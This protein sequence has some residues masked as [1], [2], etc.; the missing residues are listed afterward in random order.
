MAA[1]AH[2]AREN[3]KKGGRPKGKL[4]KSTMDAIAVKSLYVEKA[5]EYAL[6]ILQALV[7]KAL[8]GDVAAIREFNDRAYGK[9]LQK[10]ESEVNLTAV[11][12]SDEE[13]E[14]INKTLDA[15]NS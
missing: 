15:I 8:E 9:S 12:V 11:I 3:G 5:K 10:T 4:A 13:R 6:P 7:A 2:I 14:N 1:P